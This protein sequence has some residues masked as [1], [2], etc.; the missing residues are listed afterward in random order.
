MSPKQT[1]GHISTTVTDREPNFSPLDSRNSGGKNRP[2]HVI[3][4]FASFY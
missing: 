3:T 4:S 1:N 2:V